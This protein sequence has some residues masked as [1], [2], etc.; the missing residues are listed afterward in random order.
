MKRTPGSPRYAKAPQ[1][2][3]NALPKAPDAAAASPPS[4][5]N[6]GEAIAATLLVAI[7]RT[8]TRRPPEGKLGGPKVGRGH[9][10]RARPHLCKSGTGVDR[11]C[12]VVPRQPD[13][14]TQK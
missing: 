10:A 4:R 8:G 7:S 3:P 5:G 1:R 2:G 9:C 13:G 6:D 14:L 11:P 12:L